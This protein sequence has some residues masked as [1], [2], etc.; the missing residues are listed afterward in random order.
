MI[1]VTTSLVAFCLFF[2]CCFSA[3]GPSDLSPDQFPRSFQSPINGLQEL[4]RSCFDK[5]FNAILGAP[6]NARFTITAIDDFRHVMLTFKVVGTSDASKCSLIWDNS[7]P[8]LGSI[9]SVYN[10]GYGTSGDGP[11][12]GQ[13]IPMDE[14]G[15]NLYGMIFGQTGIQIDI[16]NKDFPH[17]ELI[18]FY[19]SNLVSGRFLRSFIVQGMKEHSDMVSTLSNNVQVFLRVVDSSLIREL[20]WLESGTGKT[21]FEAVWTLEYDCII[22]RY[23]SNRHLFH[24]VS[25]KCRDKLAILALSTRTFDPIRRAF[26]GMNSPI[27]RFSTSFGLELQRW[28]QSKS[29]EQISTMTIRDA[30]EDFIPRWKNSGRY[31][32]MEE[33]TLAQNTFMFFF[34]VDPDFEMIARQVLLHYDET[35]NTMS[36]VPTDDDPR[37]F[38]FSYEDS[39][40]SP[41]QDPLQPGPSEAFRTGSGGSLPPPSISAALSRTQTGSGRISLDLAGATPSGSQS[42]PALAASFGDLSVTSPLLLPRTQTDPVNIPQMGLPGTLLA[43]SHSSSPQSSQSA[44]F[45]QLSHLSLASNSGSPA[46]SGSPQIQ[47]IPFQSAQPP[48]T[49]MSVNVHQNQQPQP[50]EMATDDEE[51]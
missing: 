3:A 16:Y 15:F 42:S 32:K 40:N 10:A 45:P 51:H 12:G 24:Q 46:E 31:D 39:P 35:C 17:W 50:E 49:I 7:S 11:L 18:N 9:R 14:T 43:Q 8:E 36:G 38:H 2:H 6:K 48:A 20:Y 21:Y 25:L 13:D 41:Q 44:S 1:N 33:Q 19:P 28:V 27:Q 37:D 26:P 5:N 29:D 30:I 47:H 22:G 34:K 23:G 4:L